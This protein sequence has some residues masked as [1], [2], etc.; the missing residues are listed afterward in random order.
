[1]SFEGVYYNE[2]SK[3]IDNWIFSSERLEGD[4]L[5]NHVDGYGTFGIAY[6]VKP[7]YIDENWEEKAEKTLLNTKQKELLASIDSKY[8]INV[9][10]ASFNV[11][12]VD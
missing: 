3:E 2:D 7:S 1:M 6:I 5:L 11:A 9:K 8:V 10:D 12:N 4:T